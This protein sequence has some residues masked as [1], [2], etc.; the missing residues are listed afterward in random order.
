M[1]G[2][3]PAVLAAADRLRAAGHA[4]STPDL[5][6]GPV[7]QSLDEGFALSDRIGWATIM[8]RARDTVR[9]LPPD[10]VLAGLSMGAVVAAELLAERRD[11]AGLLLLHAIGGDPHTVRSGMPV[12]VHVGQA[13]AMFPP[14]EV[15]AW[16]GA[17]AAA[18]AAVELFS[19]PAVKHFFTDP[20]GPEYDTAAAELAWARALLFLGAL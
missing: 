13:D 20:A 16:R 7:A 5:Y 4:V 2:L 1:Y 18:G 3:R 15:A 19:Y 12:Q 9:D 17:M 11:A 8:G 6:A 10:A 14:T